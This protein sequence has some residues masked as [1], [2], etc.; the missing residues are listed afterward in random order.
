MTKRAPL[1]PHW[2]KRYIGECPACGRDASYRVRH[3]GRRP[4]HEQAR[5]KQLSYAE[6]YDHCEG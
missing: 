3:F 6:T 1:P 2:Y 5:Y 4:E